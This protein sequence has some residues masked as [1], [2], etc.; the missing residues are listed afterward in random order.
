MKQEELEQYIDTYGRELYSFCRYVTRDRQE[1]DDLYQDTFLKMCESREKLVIRKNPKGFLMAVSVNLYRNRKRKLAGRQ[2]IAEM[3]LYC[4]ELDTGLASEAC[5]VEE[6][7]V[8][9][10]KCRMLAEA[11]KQLPDKYRI[12]VLLF[13]MEE[14]PQAEI[15]DILKVAEGTVKSRICRA[16]KILRQK[17]EDM[18]YEK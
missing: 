13:Y 6:A 3:Q 16:K 14:I 10:E 12:P 15:A 9:K 8:N 11:V 2:K 4:E 5:T 1:A 18:D 7:V 17:L